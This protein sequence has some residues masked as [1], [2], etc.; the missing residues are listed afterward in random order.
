[1]NTM[2]TMLWLLTT[3]SLLVAII[4]SCL[5]W[6]FSTKV[7]ATRHRAIF[8]DPFSYP[9]VLSPSF[10]RF[11]F[12]WC[13]SVT[14]RHDVRTLHR[15]SHSLNL[16]ANFNSTVFSECFWR[17]RVIHLYQSSTIYNTT[18]NTWSLILF[19]SLLVWVICE[20]R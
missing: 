11:L 7:S 6:K 10:R 2:N 8:L 16:F 18:T 13:F 12:P 15:I 19:K 20:L 14:V 1:M 9:F 17:S 4:V 5:C 3:V